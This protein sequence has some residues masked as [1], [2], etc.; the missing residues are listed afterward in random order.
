MPPTTKVGEGTMVAEGDRTIF[1]GFDKFSFV[2]IFACVVRQGFG[3]AHRAH[4]ERVFASCYFQ[5]FSFDSRK[6]FFGNRFA[7][8]IDI[9]IETISDGRTYGELDTGVELFE[10]LCQDVR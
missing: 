6:I 2:L 3:F 1:E 7:V 8:E 10:R 9:V 4:F 5:E